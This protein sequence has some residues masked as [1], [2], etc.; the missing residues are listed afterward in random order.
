M[1]MRIAIIFIY[2][3]FF[4]IIMRGGPGGGMNFWRRGGTHPHP[5]KLALKLPLAKVARVAIESC[6][7]GGKVARVAV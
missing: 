7:G 4:I 2:R 5:F 6:A 1:Q 3:Y